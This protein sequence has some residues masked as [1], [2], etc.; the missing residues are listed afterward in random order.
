[1]TNE[2]SERAL[3]QRI[4]RRIGGYDRKTCTA[5][6]ERLCKARG[7]FAPWG[8]DVAYYTVTN[9][10]NTVMDALQRSS[11]LERYGREVGALAEWEAVA[12]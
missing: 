8:T 2:V 9:D 1:M 5:W 3:I 7:Y 12:N 4:N 11:D 10:G 6:G